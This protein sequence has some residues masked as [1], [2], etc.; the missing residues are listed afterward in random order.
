[1]TIDD[2]TLT[3]T[4]R[5]N[6]SPFCGQDGDFVTSR[7]VWDR[8]QKELQSNVALRVARDEVG[9][10]FKVSG[11]GL[12]HLGVLLETMRREG[13]EV[14]VGKPEVILK[15]P[16]E[17]E[18]NAGKLCEPIEQLVVDC[19]SECQNDVMG[20]VMNRKAEIVSRARW[21]LPALLWATPSSVRIG[22]EIA[23]GT[24]HRAT[25][26]GARTSKT[27]TAGLPAPAG[28][29]CSGSSCNGEWTG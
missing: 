17:G 11:R 1:M 21:G 25:S 4:F 10:A 19:P 13:Y 16:A 29:T 14:Q 3:M 6:D 24:P 22:S 18:E 12:M 20:L 23:P 28:N 8:L 9:D 5:V 7:Q 26:I 27:C 15:R 2:P